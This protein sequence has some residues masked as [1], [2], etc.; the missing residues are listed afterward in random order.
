MKDKTK[1]EL[2]KEL[3]DLQQENSFL[4]E[5][6]HKD[7]TEH[8]RTQEILKSQHLLLTAMLSS[9]IDI[10]IFSLDNAYCYTA[11]SEKHRE[12]MKKVWNVD[13]KIGVNLLECMRIPEIREIFKKSIDRALRGEGFTE[14]Q[15]Q[16]DF[17][18][19]YEFN[20][21]PI[22][23]KKRIV[24]VVVFIKDITERK[25]AEEALHESEEKY[26]KAFLT[27]PYAITIT[28][29]ENGKF[30]EVNNA[31]TSFS[32]FTEEEVI[33]NSAVELNMW[34]DKEEQKW[35]ISSL[36]EG[37][38]VVGKE[39]FFKRKNGEII[40]ALFYAK[41]IH[42]KNKFHILS[43]INDIT[44]RKQI[45]EK[46]QNS[47]SF[48]KETQVIANL[49]T[50]LM[51]ITTGKW[52]SSEVLDKIF[53][54]DSDFDKSVEGWASIIH[55]EWQ[56]IMTDYFNQEVIGNKIKFNKEYKI[57]RQNDK[58]E[59]WVYGIGNLKFNDNNQ[60]ITMVGTIQD[61]TERKLVELELIKAK[62]QAEESDRLKST[63]LANMSH[64]IR[65]PMNGI[66]GFT[67]LLK[68]PNL[69]VE[70]QQDFIQTIQISGSRMLNTI[71]S[72]VDMSKIDSGL[73]KVDIKE[74]NI[75]A[76]IEFIYKFFKPEVEIKGLQFLIKNSLP[77]NEA[78][79]NTDNEKF[80]A[81]LTN[82]VKNAIKFTYEGSIEFGYEKKRNY[83][84][85]FVKDTG[86]GISQNQKELI[87]ERFR[88]GSESINRKYEGSGLGLSICK[89]YVEMLSGKIWVESEEGKGSTF[90]FTIPYIAVSEEKTPIINVV[91]EKNEEVEIKKLKILVADDD[92]ISYILLNRGLKKINYDIF[93]AK[94][95]VEAVEA[96]RNNPDLDLILM[97]IKMP[98]MD[99]YEA[100]RQIRQFNKDVIII[101]QTAYALAGESE[102][103]IDAGCNDYISKPINMTALFEL[104]KKHFNKSKIC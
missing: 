1:E 102:K 17:D 68:E 78:I 49:G 53:G 74:T 20:W 5:S 34:V 22:F 84:E 31:F 38:D 86:V 55:P 58:A 71:N 43:I 27:S 91:S 30:I 29:A 94:T 83:L 80:Y 70:K 57:I 56:N 26:S 72:I 67:E 54:I 52:V 13:I 32:G 62:E 85:F 21:N 92:E 75:N 100:T 61:I 4:K 50:Y 66:L 76:K 6:Y 93:D 45:A 64:E 90:Y 51:D 2:L 10:I 97:D 82:L 33:N 44:E 42:I 95:G 15:F 41:I 47:E 14:I 87:F 59:R 69:T 9:P 46:L 7:I 3:Q 98:V 96:C 99:G 36:L 12:E 25:Q 79:I 48:L 24:G 37:R 35:V 101:A 63:F 11:F 73:M 23:Q 28:S 39:F 89:S 104:I 16:P 40:T 103:A 65:T 77:T 19:Y 8:K 88:Q 18:I 81:I 60:P